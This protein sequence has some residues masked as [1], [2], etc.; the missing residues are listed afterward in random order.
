[1]GGAAVVYRHAEGLAA[2]GHQVAVAAP[3][4]GEG[5]RSVAMRAAV[6]LRDRLHG[7]RQTPLFDPPGVQ[8]VEVG[9]P[10]AIPTGDCDAVIATGH[11]T[12]P[13]VYNQTSEGTGRPVYFLQHDERYLDAAAEETWH[14][15]MTRVAVAEWIAETLREH[16][17]D[18]AAVVPNA[19]DPAAFALDRPVR[20]RETRVVALYHRL[21]VKGPDVLV[22]ALERLREELPEV[23]ADVISARP[24][25]HHLPGWVG[26]HIRPNAETLR[27]IYNRAAVCLHTSRLEG[28]GLV[29]MEA[30]ACGC[31]VVATASR[32]V[33]EFLRD[34]RSMVEVP[35]GDGRALA[36]EAARLL[37]DVDAR[38]TMA[39]AAMEDVARFSWEESTHRFEAVLR[40]LT[41]Q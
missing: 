29:P 26:L 1:M 32:G 14:L 12:A 23:Q 30:A 40:D 34:G 20:T 39:Q 2:R 19:I 21:P 9:S 35:V 36:T 17:E 37:R 41:G 33:A 31:A 5:L 7:V 28:W 38:A 4:R 16:G 13:W 15:P 24:P 25:R 10:A 22:T 3:R 18:V 8:T 11:Q 6:L 27:A